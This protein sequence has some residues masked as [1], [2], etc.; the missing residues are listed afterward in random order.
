LEV[1]V[2][3]VA[4][5][6]ELDSRVTGQA[7]AKPDR[8]VARV[9]HAEVAVLDAPDVGRGS[10]IAAELSAVEVVDEP[11]G[12]GRNRG[13]ASDTRRRGEDQGPRGERGGCRQGQG[14]QDAWARHDAAG[15]YTR[16][17]APRGSSAMLVAGHDDR[18]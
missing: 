10:P 7:T 4:P 15:G 18:V 14:D 5:R 16:Y 2:G 3:A 9:G 1:A 12:D 6:V 8:V 17:S 11:R 13:G